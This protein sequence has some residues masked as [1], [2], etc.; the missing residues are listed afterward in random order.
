MCIASV[1]DREITCFAAVGTFATS[2]IARLYIAALIT[3]DTNEVTVATL[4]T[5][6]GAFAT[7]AIARLYVAA[8]ITF[9]TYKVT[10][11]TVTTIYTVT[12]V[13][14]TAL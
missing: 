12:T 2:A 13:A 9:D 10:I 6:V 5:A 3:L 4:I 11:T 14:W 8:L 1:E 7:S